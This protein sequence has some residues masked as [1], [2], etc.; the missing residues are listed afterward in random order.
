MS[1]AD[2]NTMKTEVDNKLKD[3]NK[4]YL[5]FIN[6]P[7]FGGGTGTMDVLNFTSTGKA[8][9]DLTGIEPT[10][11]M[12]KIL[13]NGTYYD[14]RSLG[15]NINQNT[16]FADLYAT[17]GYQC[18]EIN[19]M[20][21][22]HNVSN[23][24]QNVQTLDY[25]YGLYTLYDILN[26]DTWN[27]ILENMNS[28]TS[29]TELNINIPRFSSNNITSEKLSDVQIKYA[30]ESIGGETFI[31]DLVQS[32]NFNV[33]IARR[34][35]YM[36]ILM[37][38]FRIAYIAYQKDSSS[39][40]LKNLALL[41]LSILVSNNNMLKYQDGMDNNVEK[42]RDNQIANLTYQLWCIVV[43]TL[44]L[45]IGY[46]DQSSGTITK[47]VITDTCTAVDPSIALNNLKPNFDIL[48]KNYDLIEDD[49]YYDI[50]TTI[51]T[52]LGNYTGTS[53]PNSLNT[54]LASTLRT[55]E[56][57]AQMLLNNSIVAAN[58]AAAANNTAQQ[59]SQSS[60]VTTEKANQSSG[61]G[62]AQIPTF[63]LS[64]VTNILGKQ[65]MNIGQRFNIPF[66]LN[67]TT[68]APNIKYTLTFNIYI[69]SLGTDW[70]SIIINGDDGWPYGSGRNPGIWLTPSGWG[71]STL[72][73]IHVTH[74]TK[75][76]QNYY[77][78][79]NKTLSLN[80]IH[81]ITVTVG[82][83]E[84]NRS[85]IKLYVNGVLDIASDPNQTGTND[86]N[87]IVWLNPNKWF[88]HKGGEYGFKSDLYVFNVNWWNIVFSPDRVESYNNYIIAQNI[89]DNVRNQFTTVVSSSI[90]TQVKASLTKQQTQRTFQNTMNSYMISRMVNN[91]IRSVASLNPSSNTSILIETL[92]TN[93]T[94]FF[95]K[96]IEYRNNLSISRRPDPLYNIKLSVSDN[97]TRLK[98]N[99]SE[100]NTLG[101]AV[102]KNKGDLVSSQ[103]LLSGRKKQ[104]VTLN[105][106][107]YIELFIIVVI[108]I[109]SVIVIMAP[110]E[111]QTKLSY[112]TFLTLLVVLNIFLINYVFNR[113]SFEKFTVSN[114]DIS[115]AHIAFMNAASEYLTNT[116]NIG[117]L[118]ESNNIYGN[119]NHSLSKEISYYNNA[120]EQLVNKNLEVRSVYKTSFMTQV[121]YSATMH[122]CNIL[123]IIVIGFTISFITLESFEITGPIYTWLYVIAAILL[124]IALIIYI[125]EMKKRVRTDPKK[126]YWGQS[127]KK[128]D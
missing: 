64:G 123:G 124:V 83:G 66:T 26:K 30:L 55:L 6:Q 61:G 9:M 71:G 32:E 69:T 60:G 127:S 57:S 19:C 119:T 115:V 16:F 25:L 122:F 73:R 82:P 40:E 47:T 2:F 77:L 91:N 120:S 117:L 116:E 74:G 50:Y 108:T 34:I 27:L 96:T 68:E 90:N 95:N 87:P 5:S 22:L 42:S 49:M 79:G 41:C 31:L 4:R 59:S 76:K 13:V 38:H 1:D 11:S 14:Y 39:L 78:I 21:M 54:G 113:K 8:S 97:L 10:T 37:Y 3:F 128:I 111:K 67:P 20:G 89:T 88:F 93:T 12:V 51:H 43:Q 106:Y 81:T 126:I 63:D 101:P 35:V 80:T 65:S 94:N 56:Q 17:Y 33:F 28:D 75:N 62:K 107:I 105:I 58:S 53:C 15:E 52:A 84:Q 99:Q 92:Q 100:I 104:G 86:T 125:Y 85:I 112:T 98:Q 102:H 121:Q 114:N 29:S 118:L 110:L 48:R 23:S 44:L 36:W 46:V 70:Q 7:V 24:S 45:G 18:Q 109:L 103:K 72:P